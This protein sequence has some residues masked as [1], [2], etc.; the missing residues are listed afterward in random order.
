LDLFISLIFLNILFGLTVALVLE[1]GDKLKKLIILL[2]LQSF[3]P[4]AFSNSQ[5][6]IQPDGFTHSQRHQLRREPWKRKYKYCILITVSACVVTF[7]QT[8]RLNAHNFYVYNFF[9]KHPHDHPDV[10]RFHDQPDV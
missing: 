3:S 1:G 10:Q 8:A 2:F 6:C 7:F 5:M 4:D 9:K